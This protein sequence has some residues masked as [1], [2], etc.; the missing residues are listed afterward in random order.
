M[1][2]LTE[3]ASFQLTQRC[4]SRAL[5]FLTR[6]CKTSC[7][8]SLTPPNS[9]QCEIT[10]LRGDIPPQRYKCKVRFR[11]DS[12][13]YALR[14]VMEVAGGRAC[15]CMTRVRHPLSVQGACTLCASLTLPRRPKQEI[16][17]GAIKNS[18]VWKPC[19]EICAFFRVISK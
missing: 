3:I 10:V 1:P 6:S 16:L 13:Y 5:S 2:Y 4:E 9:M 17:Y 19:L 7:V 8:G 11:H 15:T 14:V 18:L 12:V